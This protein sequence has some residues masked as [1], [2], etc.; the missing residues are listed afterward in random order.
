MEAEIREEFDSE[1]SASP[2][3]IDEEEIDSLEVHY[4]R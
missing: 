2:N 4:T 3:D 1:F